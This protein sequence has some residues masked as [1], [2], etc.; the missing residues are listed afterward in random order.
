MGPAHIKVIPKTY[1]LALGEKWCMF[2]KY[3][4]K[5][6]KDSLSMFYN[7]FCFKY[8]GGFIQAGW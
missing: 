5:M 7:S 8:L 1:L 2:I 3:T 6:R 4:K